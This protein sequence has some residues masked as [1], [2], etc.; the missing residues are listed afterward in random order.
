[1]EKIRESENR[2]LY[3][4]N[5]IEQKILKKEGYSIYYF[6]SGNEDEKTI[7][8]L[9]PPTNLMFAVKSLRGFGLGAGSYI[10]FLI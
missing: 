1:M 6:V 3:L 8:F 10:F 9:H 2:N 5:P 4:N 7:V